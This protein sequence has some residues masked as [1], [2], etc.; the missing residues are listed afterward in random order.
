MK[1]AYDGVYSV[2]TEKLATKEDITILDG[3]YAAK[4]ARVGMADKYLQVKADKEK[5]ERSKYPNKEYIARCK[6]IM[7][8]LLPSYQQVYGNQK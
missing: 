1:H 5:E 6:K 7:D 8:N 4:Q 3:N 2:I